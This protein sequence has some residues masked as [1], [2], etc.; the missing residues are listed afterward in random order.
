MCVHGTLMWSLGK[1]FKRQPE[2]FRVYI[3]SF[4]DKQYQNEYNAE[5]FDGSRFNRF[6]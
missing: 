2:P 1:V 5:L 6:D 4:W 3:G